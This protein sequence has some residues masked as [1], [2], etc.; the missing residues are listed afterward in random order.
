MSAELYNGKELRG[1]DRRLWAEWQKLEERLEGRCDIGLQVVRR[2]ASGLPTAYLVHYLLTSICGVTNLERFGQ[3]GV[4]NEPLFATEFQMRIDIPDGYPS[5]D[6]PAAFRFLTHDEGGRPIPHPWHPNIRWFGDFA[7]RV[8]IN[9]A[10]TYTDLVWGV[11]RV[12]AY[13]RYEVYHAISEPPY[14]EDLKVA[15]WVIRQAE[16]NDWLLFSNGRQ[17]LSIGFKKEE[18]RYNTGNVP[19]AS[20]A[21]KTIESCSSLR[22]ERELYVI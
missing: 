7:G 4:I 19:Q 20:R 16:P 6:S 13:L 22:K 11:E 8:C 12:A 3:Q 18:N 14:P 10:D 15:S 5:I 1:R 2:N 21:E 9:M 17:E